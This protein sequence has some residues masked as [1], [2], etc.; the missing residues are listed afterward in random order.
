[1][2]FEFSR[3]ILQ[4]SSNIKFHE[5]SSSGNLVIP[6][7]ETAGQTDITKSIVA[8][9]NFSIIIKT[10]KFLLSEPLQWAFNC[11]PQPLY[12][13]KETPLRIE[14]ESE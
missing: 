6:R 5:N 11:V 9:R 2:K 1:M 8:L 4:Q 14:Y 13:Q 3:Q 12:P 7:G 10:E